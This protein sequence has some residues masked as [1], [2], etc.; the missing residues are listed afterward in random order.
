MSN[1]DVAR[2]CIEAITRRDVATLEQL[3]TADVE[4]V[5]LRAMVEDTVYRG[6]EGISRW[7]RDIGETW[8]ELGIEIESIDE[9]RP[10]FV[11]ARVTLH[12]R[13][14]GSNVPTQMRVELTAQLRDGLVAE[15]TTRLGS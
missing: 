15:A 4:I 2:R 7:M 11:V 3:S 1:V 9:V 10:D 8:A 5:P 12:G 14:H 6:R 13:G